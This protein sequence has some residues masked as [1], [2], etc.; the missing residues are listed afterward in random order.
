MTA[1]GF[2]DK[3]MGTTRTE[4][5]RAGQKARIHSGAVGGKQPGSGYSGGT[6][7]AARVCD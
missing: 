3:V 2:P 5:E 4:T 1:G 6:A 7:A